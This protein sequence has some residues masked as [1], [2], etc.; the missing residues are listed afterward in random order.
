MNLFNLTIAISKDISMSRPQRNQ[1][2]PN[3]EITARQL[4]CYPLYFYTIWCYR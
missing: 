4:V 2:K 3:D 1:I